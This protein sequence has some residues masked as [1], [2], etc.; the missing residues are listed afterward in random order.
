LPSSSDSS[1]VFDNVV[2]TYRRRSVFG[3]K[4]ALLHLPKVIHEW[5]SAHEHRVLDGISFT[6]RRGESFGVVGRNGAGKSTMLG[7]IARVLRPTAG[8]V[9]VSGRIAPLLQLGAGFHQEL[10]GRDNIVLNAILLGLSRREA[11]ARTEAIIDF[12][13]L[14]EHIDEPM[15]TY[16]S[17][18]YMRLGF[19][20]GAHT[21][22]EILLLDEVLAVGDLPFQQK[23]LDTLRDFRRQ[24]VTLV[25]VSHDLGQVRDTCDRA[26]LLENARVETIGT[27]DEVEKRYRALFAS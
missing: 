19:A 18:M 27:P 16:S 12:A 15:R 6:V 21:D 1:V 8:R 22:P 3:L 7:L 14:R 25:L 9:R 2:K 5:R 24:G 23:C 26:L 4:Q 13:G 10:S 20:V 17:G 11:R